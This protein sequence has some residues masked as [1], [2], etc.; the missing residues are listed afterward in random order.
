LKNKAKLYPIKFNPIFKEK[1]WGGY[2]LSKF[3]KKETNS[4]IGESWELS[5]VEGSISIVSEGVL[6]GKSLTE[7]IDI[8]KAELVGEKVFKTF[9]NKFPLL[10]KFI[11]AHEDLSVQLHPNDKLAKERHNSFGKT[12]M[13]YILDSEKESR[14]IL[15]FNE[16][17]DEGKYLKSLSEDKLINILR[18]EKVTPGEAY[19][20]QP[21]TVHAI[22]AGIV[23][24]E[25]QQTSDITYRIYDW[26]RPDTDGTLREL[27]TDLAVEAIN[28]KKHNAKL[29]YSEKAN[30][31]VEICNSPYF[32]T[33]KIQ[34]TQ[35]FNRDLS[36]IDSFIVYM[37]IEGEGIIEIGDIS[38]KIKKGETVLIPANATILAIYTKNATFLE[39]YIP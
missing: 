23:L 1:V 24:A 27:H 7:I 35:N 18:S 19:F 15:G 25:I 10:F 36:H 16:R 3:L 11:D 5:G 17:M 37:C 20:I 26:N 31:P 4:K 30:K 12:E 13:W 29:L 28:Y 14:L 9:G 21:G 39:V 33:N 6:K 32:I 8:Y 2:K 38:E 34:L 22:G